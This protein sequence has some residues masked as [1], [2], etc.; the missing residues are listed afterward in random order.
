MRIIFA[1]TP[2][3]A[4]HNLKALLT[5]EHTICAIYTQPDRPAGRGRKLTASPVKQIGLDNNIPVEQ[6]NNFKQ[7][8]DRDTLAAY[9]AD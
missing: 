3:F 6:P 8:S 5:S 4:A 1:G 9:Q 7:Q 2:D